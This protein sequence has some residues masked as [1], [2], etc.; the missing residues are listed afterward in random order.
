MDNGI[1]NEGSVLKRDKPDPNVVAVR[2][3]AVQVGDV[4]QFYRHVSK[5]P[6]LRL[7]IKI[8]QSFETVEGSIWK[9]IR[10]DYQDGSYQNLEPFYKATTLNV[11]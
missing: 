11:F 5:P 2:A 4:V 9:A 10:F 1:A 8:S 6:S 3:D 7:V